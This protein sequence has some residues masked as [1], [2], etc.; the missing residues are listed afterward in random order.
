V[1]RESL[2]SHD[3]LHSL[4]FREGEHPQFRVGAYTFGAAR[5]L[6]NTE[7]WSVALGGDF[8]FYSK[9]AVLDALYGRAPTSYKLFLRVRPRKMKH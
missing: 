1:D 3:E 6:W 4:G 9:P 5:D 8:T 7:K 2:L